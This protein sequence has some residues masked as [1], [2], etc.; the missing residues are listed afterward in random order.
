MNM[1][2]GI[3]VIVHHDN[4]LDPLIGQNRR[5]NLFSLS[6]IPFLDPHNAVKIGAA[7]FCKVDIKDALLG[8]HAGHQLVD[9]RHVSDQHRLVFIW[10]GAGDDIVVNGMI[11][12]GNGFYIKDRSQPLVPIVTGEFNKGSLQLP[13]VGR[14]LSFQNNLCRG[15]HFEIDGLAPDHIYRL[16][17]LRPSE[18]ELVFFQRH[19]GRSGHHAVRIDADGHGHGASFPLLPITHDDVPEVK[20]AHP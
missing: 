7:P 10:R 15:R 19:A 3:D 18:C 17:P 2:T 13:L 14:D 5:G 20:W 8:K 11:P 6:W 4:V 1:V 12:V 9:L 16:S